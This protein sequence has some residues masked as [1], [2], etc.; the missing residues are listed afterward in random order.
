MN[1]VAIKM[2]LAGPLAGANKVIN[3]H[4]FR[5]GVCYLE[6]DPT[7]LGGAIKYLATYQAYPEGSPEL[8]VEP[9]EPDHGTEA[10]SDPGADEPNGE[11]DPQGENE[12]RGDEQPEDP[13]FSFGDGDSEP[14]QAGVRSE[15]DGHEG[16]QVDPDPELEVGNGDKLRDAILS[17]DPEDDSHWTAGGKPKMDAVAAAYGSEGLVRADVNSAVPGW[18]RDRA[19]EQAAL[20]EIE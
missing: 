19:R 2:I 11:E 15:G 8:A 7:Q 6:G 9:E 20:R 1:N 5:D 10:A 12:P 13:T 14:G 17:L 16:S 18:D 4:V 3:G